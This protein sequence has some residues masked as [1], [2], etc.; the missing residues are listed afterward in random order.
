M[1]LVQTPVHTFNTSHYR[2]YFLFP[3]IEIT[4]GDNRKLIC[5]SETEFEK[6]LIEIIQPFQINR[7]ECLIWAS[8]K[9]YLKVVKHLVEDIPNISVAAEY[10]WAEIHAEKNSQYKVF[11]YLKSNSAKIRKR[12]ST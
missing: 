6:C 12:F 2:I 7:G 5:N 1:N 10:E 9:G 8:K 4:Q 11:N 3:K